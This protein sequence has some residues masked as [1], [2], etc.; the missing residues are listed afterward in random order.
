MSEGKRMKKSKRFRKNR[1]NNIIYVGIVLC[2][3]LIV[4]S[5]AI[6]FW[7]EDSK[8]EWPKFEISKIELPNIEWFKDKDKE[9]KED[10]DDSNDNKNKSSNLKKETSEERAREIAVAEF[11][12][13][14]DKVSKES[15][16]V[17]NLERKD[18]L[19]YYYIKSEK[20]TCEVRKQDGVLTRL[21]ANPVNQ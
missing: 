1:R 7:P 21:N 16:T 4:A 6:L 13:L 20:N 17:L 11:E 14:G 9:D 5:I 10:K 15:L 2:I 18:G 12:K 8:F 19:M 3:I